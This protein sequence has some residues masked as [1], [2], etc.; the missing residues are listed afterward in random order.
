VDY[1]LNRKNLSLGIVLF[2]I[3]LFVSLFY[4]FSIVGSEW[5]YDE[6]L[7]YKVGKIYLERGLIQG[8]RGAFLVNAEHPPLGKISIGLLSILLSSFNLDKYPIPSRVFAAL[9]LGILCTVQFLIGRKLFGAQGGFVSWGLLF[10]QFFLFPP[11]PIKLG[12][13]WPLAGTDILFITFQSL[14]IYFLYDFSKGR[15]LYYSSFFFGLSLLCK[16]QALYTSIAIATTWMIWK[17]GRVWPVLK[18]LLTFLAFGLLVGVVGNPV[19]CTPSFYPVLAE[20]LWWT[21]S[22]G[23]GRTIFLHT[24]FLEALV[25]DRSSRFLSELTVLIVYI[26]VYPT[27]IFSNLYLA[28]ISIVSFLTAYIRG[29]RI[30]DNRIFPLIW[31]SWVLILFLDLFKR[32]IAYYYIHYIPALAL[33]STPLSLFVLSLL[34]KQASFHMKR[35][36]G[37]E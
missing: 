34:K 18:Q 28:S 27:K 2:I 31:F 20:R 5:W 35:R 1:N 33:Y 25:Q 36:G 26:L 4:G 8:D 32:N 9:S 10:S 29:K 13:G 14:M 24:P 3:P 30:E 16:Y 37:S 17:E 23:P 7:Y 15:N 6:E 21:Q 11:V 22:W 19:L 12:G